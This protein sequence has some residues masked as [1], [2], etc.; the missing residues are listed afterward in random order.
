[1][2]ALALSAAFAALPAVLVAPD[3][4]AQDSDRGRFAVGAQVGT[5]GVG[6][7][8]Q[9][10]VNDYIVLRGGYDLLR[11]E[12]D[13]T[14]D[15]IEYEA[16]IDFQSPGAFVDLHP[17]RNGF[18]V[19]AG[20]YLGDR[21]VDLKSDPDEDVEIGGFTFTP[22]QVGTLTGRIDLESTAPF[23]GLGF[24]NSFTRDGR[25]GFRVL[26]GAVFGDAPQVNLEASGGTLSNQPLFQTLLAQEEQE[27]QDEADD[28][29]ILPVVQIGLNYRF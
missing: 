26:A 25:L 4:F 9:Y 11:W 22:E 16:D 28:Y 23:L 14:Y 12:T 13:D 3:A 6:V 20:A 5:P 29:E 27:I 10:S 1:M 17:F 21:G 2:K 19:S 8:V 24:D 15:G 7:Q 18:F